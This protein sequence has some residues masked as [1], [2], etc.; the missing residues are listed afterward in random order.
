MAQTSVHAADGRR[1][2]LAAVLLVGSLPWFLAGCESE[3]PAQMRQA[4]EQRCAIQGFHPGS[5]PFA[6]CVRREHGQIGQ[7]AG[8]LWAPPFGSGDW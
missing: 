7:A 8:P 1:T 3:S 5:A 4:D 2:I 6:D